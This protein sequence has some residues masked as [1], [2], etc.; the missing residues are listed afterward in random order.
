MYYIMFLTIF[1]YSLSSFIFIFVVHYL[2][3]YFK[4]NLTVPKEKDMIE[5]PREAYNK[6]YETLQVH[7][8]KVKL[9]NDMKDELK[10]YLN[11]LK[12]NKIHNAEQ[13]SNNSNEDNSNVGTFNI[14]SGNIGFSTINDVTNE[15]NSFTPF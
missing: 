13:K 14:D 4:D 15:I 11:E 5:K 9:N 10:N 8:D 1:N 7:E 6:I 12:K 2:Y 3:E